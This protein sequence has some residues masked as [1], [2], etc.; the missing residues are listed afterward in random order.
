MV[1]TYLTHS[2]H[3]KVH[4]DA[5][6]SRVRGGVLGRGCNWKF[7]CDEEGWIGIS[8]VWR[9]GREYGHS[10]TWFEIWLGSWWVSVLSS[11]VFILV[12][13]VHKFQTSTYT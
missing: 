1:S 12:F 8:V 11:D 10:R 9:G 7:I 3:S 4:G 2:A 5:R 6:F 13:K